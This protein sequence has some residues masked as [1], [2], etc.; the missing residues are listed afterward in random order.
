MGQLPNKMDGEYAVL[1]NRFTT[2]P[3]KLPISSSSNTLTTGL[4]KGFRRIE[5]ETLFQFDTQF[6]TQKHRKDEL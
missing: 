6:D 3:N 1:C 2:A 5:F 4:T